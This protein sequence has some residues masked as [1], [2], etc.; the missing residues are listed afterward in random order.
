MSSLIARLT[1]A[2]SLLAGCVRFEDHDIGPCWALPCGECLAL[3][4][5]AWDTSDNLCRQSNQIPQGHGQHRVSARCPADQRAVPT[6]AG[7]DVADG[8]TR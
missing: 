8:R 5:C 3:S 6:D 2:A 4:A 1:L 7:A